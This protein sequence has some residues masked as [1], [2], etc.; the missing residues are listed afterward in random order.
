MR[1]YVLA[2]PALLAVGSACLAGATHAAKPGHVPKAH[3]GVRIVLADVRDLPIVTAA[4]TLGTEL[5]AVLLPIAMV[6]LAWPVAQVEQ[7]LWRKPPWGRKPLPP[8]LVAQLERL[9]TQ[10][11]LPV[12]TA[13]D[14]ERRFTGL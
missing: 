5:L 10:P 13:K 2:V 6:A 14:A 4:G 12:A 3:A 1:R 7:W 8:D 9:R 11:L